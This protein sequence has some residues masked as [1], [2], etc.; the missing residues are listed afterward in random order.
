MQ[1]ITVNNKFKVIPSKIDGD[2]EIIKKV[3]E[4]FNTLPIFLSKFDVPVNPYINGGVID[5]VKD[6][7]SLISS[8]DEESLYKFMKE[9]DGIFNIPTEQM[10][11]AWVAYSPYFENPMMKQFAMETLENDIKMLITEGKLTQT[12]NIY[13]GLADDMTTIN[14]W[15]DYNDTL[16]RRLKDE[17]LM[18]DTLAATLNQI[19]GVPFTDFE[20]QKKYVSIKLNE[21]GVE[22]PFA[23]IF[24]NIVLNN[25]IPF[26]TFGDLFK[27]YKSF[28]PSMEWYEDTT[29]DSITLYLRYNYNKEIIDE[30]EEVREDKWGNFNKV[31]IFRDSQ[32]IITIES[33]IRGDDKSNDKD[34]VTQSILDVLK[35]SSVISIGSISVEKISGVFYIPLQNM[36]IQIFQDMIMNDKMFRSF[37]AVNENSMVSGA[38]TKRKNILFVQYTDPSDKTNILTSFAPKIMSRTQYEM[39]DKDPKI[40]PIGKPFLKVKIN[41][42][43]NRDAITQFQTIIS[44]L[45][46]LYNDGDEAVVKSYKSYIPGFVLYPPVDDLTDKLRDVAPDVFKSKYTKLCPKERNPIPIESSEIGNYDKGEA[47]VFPKTEE[48]GLQRIYACPSEEFPQLGLIDNKLENKGK[49]PYLPCCFSQPQIDDTKTKYWKY[50]QKGE[51]DEDQTLKKN[52]RILTTKK[53]ATLNIFGVL[54]ENIV[55]MFSIIDKNNVYY[56]KGVSVGDSSFLASVLD[57]IDYNGFRNITDVD[58][59][60]KILISERARIANSILPEVCMQQCY[61]LTGEDIK[62]MIS[63]P[64]VYLSPEYFVRALETVYKINIIIFGRDEDSNV[65]GNIILPRHTNGYV[66]NLIGGANKPTIFV[67]DHTGGIWEN[68]NSTE[69]IVRK[70]VSSQDFEYAFKTGD[71]VVKMVY[72]FE[73]SLYQFFQHQSKILYRNIP[74]EDL[75]KRQFIDE[76]GKVRMIEY[77]VKGSVVRT[78]TEPLPPTNKQSIEISDDSIYIPNNL[79]DVLTLIKDWD[80]VVISEQVVDTFGKITE[81][82]VVYKNINYVFSLSPSEK[83]PGID[84]SSESN[85][86]KQL[87]SGISEYIYNERY[88]RQLTEYVKYKFSKSGLKDDSDGFGK[89]IDDTF[90]IE[91][92]GNPELY[93]YILDKNPKKIIVKSKQLIKPVVYNLRVALFNKPKEIEKYKTETFMNNYYVN[94][95]DFKKYPNQTVLSGVENITK[96]SSDDISKTLY[97]GEI[98]T[99]YRIPYF[100]RYNNTNYIA[101][102]ADTYIDALSI[103]GNWF[104]NGFNQGYGSTQLP[105]DRLPVNTLL[106]YVNGAFADPIFVNG[107]EDNGNEYIVAV[108]KELDDYRYT[109]LLKL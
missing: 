54:P 62:I 48:E 63:D 26:S 72:G 100:I 17:N 41:N 99:F 21:N 93:S 46:K 22:Y 28:V 98:K 39:K 10:L 78:F 1:E 101:Q 14:R 59:R 69:L 23:Y 52:K 57:G 51:G 35:L 19:E 24:D 60:A 84:T 97:N 45:I 61:D 76:Y 32:G 107:Y 55:E 106:P 89:F 71:P 16:F 80:G 44:K 68:F 40:F 2:Q 87:N 105:E 108:N 5:G 70:N 79:N 102:P 91:S 90:T 29:E 18:N 20:P 86:P 75:V 6:L 49:Y 25:K 31:N 66:H 73:T 109:A 82:T 56:R 50:Y 4:K 13:L 47:A 77:N 92:T 8:G 42:G 30:D 83:L 15:S 11:Y 94:I 96:W 74:S 9:V 81:I 12:A 37:L 58:E 27:I 34:I 104:V 3:A 88:S 53:F 33:E 67:Y 65:D 95:N 38:N 43:Q 64:E 36:N 85:I 7:K 103:L